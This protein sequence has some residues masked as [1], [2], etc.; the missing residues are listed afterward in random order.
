MRNTS[1]LFHAQMNTLLGSLLLSTNGTHLTAV[2]FA[3]Q[4]DRPA[5]GGLPEFASDAGSPTAGLKDGQP[6][7]HIKFSQ[8]GCLPQ[9]GRQTSQTPVK[10]SSDSTLTYLQSDTPAGAAAVL[11][12]T[13]DQ[14]AQYFDGQ[15]QEFALPLQPVGTPFQQKVWQ[16]LLAIPYAQLRSYGQIASEAG[17]SMRHGRP[18]GTAVGRNPISIVI[19][20]HRVLSAS[21]AL[22]GY[23]GGLHRKLALLELE[24]LTFE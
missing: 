9:L 22:T 8:Q 6:L 11:K 10:Q 20:C 16:A 3:D 21:G 15:R 18:V 1:T 19:P 17:L 5:L 24:G 12:N 7:K 14:L 13:C 4:H 2:C 23:T